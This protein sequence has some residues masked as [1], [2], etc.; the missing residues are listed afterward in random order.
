M[1]TT[2]FFSFNRICASNTFK[3]N[4]TA[5]RTIQSN[6]LSADMRAQHSSSSTVRAQ[7]SLLLF[8][9]NCKQYFF[10]CENSLS[11]LLVLLPFFSYLVSPQPIES[12]PP[13]FASVSPH[14]TYTLRIR[15][16]HDRRNYK[17]PSQT[18]P[19]NNFNIN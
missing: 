3:Y 5:R 1:T 16:F 15:V 7:S 17:P 2:I 8:P 11:P 6:P 18:K 13:L 12:S 19:R 9:Q 10:F 4:N 14:L